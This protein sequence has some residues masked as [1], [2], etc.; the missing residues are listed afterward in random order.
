MSFDRSAQG[1]YSMLL[2]FVGRKISLNFWSDKTFG[3]P[4]E[5]LKLSGNWKIPG[6]VREFGHKSENSQTIGSKELM[7][8]IF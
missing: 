2:R 5:K 7:D 8:L 3:T 4:R 1:P 6:N